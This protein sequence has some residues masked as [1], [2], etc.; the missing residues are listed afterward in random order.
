MTAQLYYLALI[1]TLALPDMCAGLAAADGRSNGR[2]YAEWWD[3]NM[4]WYSGQVPWDEPW[5]TVDPGDQIS[6]YDMYKFRC[7]MLHQGV[8]IPDPGSRLRRIVV[9]EPESRVQSHL[10]QREGIMHVSLSSL[11]ADVTRGAAAWLNRE[12]ENP[13]VTRNREQSARRRP[14]G[15]YYPSP[16]FT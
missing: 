13:T 10:N 14:D 4:P 11:V 9:I 8:A 16:H 5:Q 12:A 15:L 6:G 2:R 3:E 7:S 1:G